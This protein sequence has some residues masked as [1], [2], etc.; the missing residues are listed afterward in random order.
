MASP[1]QIRTRVLAYYRKL[2]PGADETLIFKDKGRKPQQVEDDGEQLAI[3]LNCDPDR[4]DIVACK[5][6]GAM[7]DL[8]VR[9][10]KTTAGV[11]HESAMVGLRVSRLLPRRR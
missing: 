6:I 2:F 10:R 9:T 5:T 8:L 7:I 3:E 1:K 4:T 11:L